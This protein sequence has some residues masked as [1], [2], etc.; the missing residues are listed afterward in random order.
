MAECTDHPVSSFDLLTKSLANGVSRRDALRLVAGGLTGAL[1]T[2]LGVRKA[3]AGAKC[4]DPGVCGSYTN[5]G[6]DCSCVTTSKPG[7]GFCAQHDLCDNLPACSV[8]RDCRQLL[9]RGWKCAQA[10]CCDDKPNVCVAKCG[11]ITSGTG[12]GRRWS[13]G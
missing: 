12:S 8:N 10:T 4:N 7:K 13:G 1:L 5:C 3:H 11:S 9:G 2:T 6:S